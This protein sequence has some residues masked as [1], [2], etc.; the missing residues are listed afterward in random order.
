MKNIAVTT[1]QLIEQIEIVIKRMR[2]K[3]I[4]QDMMGNKNETG[5]H[6]LKSQK[7]PPL[8]NKL[9]TFEVDLIYLVKNIKFRRVH[10]HLQITSK[11]D[12]NLINDQVRP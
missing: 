10:S 9:A 2:W 12:Q 1:E 5:I 11:S 7:T 4:Y 8:I 6:G 3:V